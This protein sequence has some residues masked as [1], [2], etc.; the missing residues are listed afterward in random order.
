MSFE[1]ALAKLRQSF[2]AYMKDNVLSKVTM[3]ENL[4][5][6]GICFSHSKQV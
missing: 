3:N 2:G 6:I 4:G 5:K 1:S